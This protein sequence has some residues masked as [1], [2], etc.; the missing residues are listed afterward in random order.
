VNIGKVSSCFNKGLLSL[1]VQ[2]ETVRNDPQVSIQAH[3]SLE[4]T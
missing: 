2:D 1:L 4:G 3:N